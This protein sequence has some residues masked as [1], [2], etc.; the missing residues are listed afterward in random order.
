M[1]WACN[2]GLAL[3]WAG[4]LLARPSLVAAA[5]L[6][7]AIDQLLWRV[8]RAV[9]CAPPCARAARRGARCATIVGQET[10]T[11]CSTSAEAARRLT[12][13]E[14]HLSARALLLFAAGSVAMRRRPPDDGR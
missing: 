9:C 13:I 1:L 12:S 14:V 6:S 3:A 7:V 5:A 8:A 11:T 2:F 10:D 4:A